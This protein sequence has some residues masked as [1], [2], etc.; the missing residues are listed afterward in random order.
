MWILLWGRLCRWMLF[1][2]FRVH[3]FFIISLTLPFPFTAILFLAYMH[4]LV[5]GFTDG[6]NGSSTFFFPFLSL[7]YS[8][9]TWTGGVAYLEGG[10]VCG[11]NCCEYHSINDF[12]VSPEGLI[13]SERSTGSVSLVRSRTVLMQCHSRRTIW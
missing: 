7:L 8:G 5:Y 4:H 11:F 9:Y 13:L 2:R 1:D 3:L 6:K 12:K 10:F